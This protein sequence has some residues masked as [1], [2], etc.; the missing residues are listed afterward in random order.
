MNIKAR[1][2]TI[3]SDRIN[4]EDKEIKIIINQDEKFKGTLPTDKEIEEHKKILEPR[5]EFDSYCLNSHL[6]IKL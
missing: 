3:E 4:V 1:T 2:L 6:G 5:V